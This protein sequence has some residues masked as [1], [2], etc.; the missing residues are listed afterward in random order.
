MPGQQL[1][2][3]SHIISRSSRSV[4]Q[5]LQGHPT[6]RLILVKICSPEDL[7]SPPTIIG[8][9]CDEKLEY[10][11]AQIFV[12]GKVMPVVFGEIKMS[13][14]VSTKKSQLAF[15][16][17]QQQLINLGSNISFPRIF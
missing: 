14:W 2:R 8:L 1:I 10:C 15:S 7:L 11:L 16:E 3:N 6:Y 17:R 13:F 12:I 9:K 5:K 4:E